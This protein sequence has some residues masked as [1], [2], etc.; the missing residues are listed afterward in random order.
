MAFALRHRPAVR[1]DGCCVHGTM[2]HR[3]A[4]QIGRRRE[5]RHLPVRREAP[6]LERSEHLDACL[7]PVA[8]LAVVPDALGERSDIVLE[9]GSLGVPGGPQRP[10]VVL[11]L[12]YLRQSP[13][14]LVDAVVVC[15][16]SILV[17]RAHQR[18]VAVVGPGVERAG[19]HECVALVV[20]AN[21]HASVGARVEECA[22]LIVLS[23]ANHQH[24][25]RPHPRHEEVSRIRHLALVS[26]EQPALAVYLLQFLLE[27]VLVDVQLPAHR[28]LISVDERPEEIVLR[29]R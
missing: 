15:I 16:G 26:E 1:A 24:L 3:G 9:R 4:R 17:G 10:V 21:L 20:P 8:R 19:E 25:L 11:K 23:A 22:Y 13:L 18:A 12:G 5:C 29:V 27:D 14:L 6:L 2:G 28:A 7:C